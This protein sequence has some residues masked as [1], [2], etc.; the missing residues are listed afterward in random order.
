LRLAKKCAHHIGERAPFIEKGKYIAAF[1]SSEA[2]PYPT[3]HRVKI[4][5]ATDG[6][7]VTS[8]PKMFVPLGVWLMNQH[9]RMDNE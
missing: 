3:E 4:F 9:C 1:W 2:E 6:K 5:S 7:L 8:G